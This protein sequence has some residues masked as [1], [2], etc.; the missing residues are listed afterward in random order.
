MQYVKKISALLLIWFMLIAVGSAKQPE[1]RTMQSYT[2]SYYSDFLSKVLIPDIEKFID[3]YKISPYSEERGK[4]LIQGVISIVQ[5]HLSSNNVLIPP[6]RKYPVTLV[7]IPP[8][9]DK[10][11]VYYINVI[12]P[13]VEY[14]PRGKIN[15]VLMISKNFYC[16]HESLAKKENI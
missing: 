9:K 4:E 3:Q 12:F 11:I 10:I 15:S 14:D 2:F 1:K 5:S 8:D 6:G 7:V 13:F 16:G